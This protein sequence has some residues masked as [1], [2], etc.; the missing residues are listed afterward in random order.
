MFARVTGSQFF[1]RKKLLIFELKMFARA[2][3]II[4][5]K[6]QNFTETYVEG[7]KLKI[8]NDDS[9]EPANFYN[10]PIPAS[11]LGMYHLKCSSFLLAYLKVNFFV[12]HD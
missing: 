9:N 6:V 1:R 8:I 5:M 7:W 11:K 3:G 12:I 2:I 4:V 10:E